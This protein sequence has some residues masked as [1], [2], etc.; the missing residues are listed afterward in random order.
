MENQQP[1]V[2]QYLLNVMQQQQQQQH[3]DSSQ[4]NQYFKLDNELSNNQ[5]GE[6]KTRRTKKDQNDRK[7]ICGCGKS[8]LSY[9]ALYTHLKQLEIKINQILNYFQKYRKHNGQPPESTI[10]PSITGKQN[11]R[12]RP[13]KKEEIS[14]LQKEEEEKSLEQSEQADILEDLLNFLD[15]IDKNYHQ[16]LSDIFPTIFFDCKSENEYKVLLDGIKNLEDDSLNYLVEQLDSKGDLKKTP[17]NKIF[18]LFINYIAKGISNLALKEIIIF[19]CFYRKALNQYGWNALEQKLNSN[20]NEEFGEQQ[21]QNTNNQNLITIDPQLREQEF[22]QVNNGDDCFLICNDFIIEI[23]PSY[24]Q[25]YSTESLNIIG[26]SDEQL[27]NA[28]YI[29]Q[30]FANWLFNNR[31]TNTKLSIFPDKPEDE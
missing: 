6:K 17:M 5:N 23:L 26:P 19:L 4:L 11:N 8:Y 3:Q 28:V 9:P 25:E 16:K 29:I 13:P 1:Q 30:H 27:K 22:C 21:Q 24:L 10:L 18:V 14:D 7:Y 15:T 20:L 12:G 2:Q 31:Y